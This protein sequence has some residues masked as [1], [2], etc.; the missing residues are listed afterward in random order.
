LLRRNKTRFVMPSVAADTIFALSSGLPPSG[1]A[2]LRVSG[3]H[4]AESLEALAGGLPPTRLA[5]RRTLFN[6]AGDPVDDAIVLWF[7]APH[8][9]TGEAVA[10]FH[11]H[12]GRAIIAALVAALSAVPGLRPAEPGE[13]TRRAYE[14]GKIDLVAAEALDD[15]IHAQTEQQRRLAF[16]QFGGLLGAQARDWRA[17]IIAASAL[18]EAGI[19]FSDESDVAHGTLTAA[20]EEALQLRGQIATALARSGRSERL[21]EGL[22]VAIAG[23]PNAGKSTLLNCIAGRDVAIVSPY[24]GTTRDALEVQLDLGGYPVTLID[25]AGLRE[26]DDVVEQEGIRRALARAAEADLVLW[27][28]EGNMDAGPPQDVAATELWIV[29]TKA[30]QGATTGARALSG[31]T[32]QGVPELLSELEAFAQ[33]QFPQDSAL[34]TRERHRLA[35]NAVVAAL[36]RAAACIE[37]ELLAEELRLAAF[38]LG[39]LLGRI[40]VE[41]VLGDIFSRFC[42]GK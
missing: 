10:E 14:N 3:P 18:V 41:D 34:V 38:E 36:D 20:K 40:D 29:R 31:R 26:T 15:L 33:R 21:R 24:P 12:G 23:P 5:T 25:T 11:V 1:I 35:L 13:F 27:L 8:S 39:R 37:A 9:A 28:A 4:A 6:E 17:R 19:D 42:I 7:P 32:G 16:Q 22:T 30:D 2:V